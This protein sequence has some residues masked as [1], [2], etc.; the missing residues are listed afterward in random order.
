VESRA[1]CAGICFV[2]VGSAGPCCIGLWITVNTCC[3]WLE[4]WAASCGGL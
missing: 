3:C 4:T 2:C 1:I